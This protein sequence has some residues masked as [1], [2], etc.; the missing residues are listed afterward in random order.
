MVIINLLGKKC[1]GILENEENGIDN[2][3]LFP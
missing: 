2:I 3:M 1:E